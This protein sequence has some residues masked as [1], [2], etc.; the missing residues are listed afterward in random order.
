MKKHG[1]QKSPKRRQVLSFTL[2][3]LLVVIAIIAILASMLLPAL[4]KARDRAKKINC[5]NNLKQIGTAAQMY[6][7]DHDGVIFFRGT[8]K[9]QT[10]FVSLNEYIKIKKTFKCP[11]YAKTWKFNMWNLYYGCNYNYCPKDQKEVHKIKKIGMFKQPSARLIIADCDNGTGDPYAVRRNNAGYPISL[12]HEAQ[13]N[14]GWLD[15][16]VESKPT[17]EINANTTYWSFP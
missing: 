17:L 16:H 10:W 2:I 1:E 15:G 3:E 14:I 9:Y 11:A 8:F 5:A 13:P 12:R 6:Y 4:N 7:N